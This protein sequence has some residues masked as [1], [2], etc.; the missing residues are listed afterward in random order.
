MYNFRTGSMTPEGKVKSAVKKLLKRYG[1][2][3]YGDWP[4]PGGYGKSVLDYHGCVNGRYFAIETKA[5][6]GKPTARQDL[7]IN[8]ITMAGA[9]VFVIDGVECHQYAALETWL[10]ANATTL[11]HKKAA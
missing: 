2:Q 7:T 9:M 3:I 4:V 8:E 1:S 10:N 11:E 6:G 5:P